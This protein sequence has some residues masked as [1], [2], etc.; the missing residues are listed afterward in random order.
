MCFGLMLDDALERSRKLTGAGP[1]LRRERCGV[2]Y[3]AMFCAHEL[4]ANCGPATAPSELAVLSSMGERGEESSS[5]G[6]A[7]GTECKRKLQ[8]SV[9]MWGRWQLRYCW[10]TRRAVTLHQQDGDAGRKRTRGARVADST[11]MH[12]HDT[13]VTAADLW[14]LTISMCVSSNGPPHSAHFSSLTCTLLSSAIF[15][16]VAT[17]DA[18]LARP[19]PAA[20]SAAFFACSMNQKS[21]SC[22]S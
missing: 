22:C 1:T 8:T 20:A 18:G 19:P 2:F 3:C 10:C 7:Q 15:G 9:M 16:V 14:P 4:C 12:T 13:N 17:G 11:G 5:A 21:V 6:V